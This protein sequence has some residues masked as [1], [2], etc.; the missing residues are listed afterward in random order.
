MQFYDGVIRCLKR[1]HI[2]SMPEDAKG[3]VRILKAIALL[4]FVCLFG[5]SL[6]CLFVSIMRQ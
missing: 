4:G 5:F 6:F 1:M 2:K 3:Q